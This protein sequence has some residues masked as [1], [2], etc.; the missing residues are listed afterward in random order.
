MLIILLL[1][2]G[3]YGMIQLHPYEY[4]YYNSFI[5]GTGGVFRHYETDY[6]LTCYKQAVEE[7]DQLE[8]RSRSTFISTVYRSGRAIRR[9]QR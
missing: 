1:A 8:S 3:I 2:P 7:F 5:G 9:K 6:W 4:T